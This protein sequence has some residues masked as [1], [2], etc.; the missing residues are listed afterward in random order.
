VADRDRLITGEHVQRGDVLIGLPSP[1]LRSNGYSL[2]RRVLLENAGRD[3]HE[4]AWSG[5]PHSLAD[6]LLVPSVVYAPAIAALLRHVDVRAIA[7]V[8]GGGLPGNVT[9]VLPDGADAQID[10]GTWE[11][12]RIF[13]EIQRLG[14]VSDDEMRKVFNLGIGMVVVVA[15]DEV[16]RTLD[17]LR[18][19]GHRAVQ[20]GEIVTGHGQVRFG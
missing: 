11:S 2:A 15:A 7:H 6:E 4:P 10:P 1:G 8:T 14:E 17:L 13:G 12:P 20:I 16:H 3:L 9:R 19:E 18:T 5:A